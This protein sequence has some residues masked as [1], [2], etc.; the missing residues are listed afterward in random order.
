[1]A[2]ETFRSRISR[3]AGAYQND[4]SC[5][6][7]PEHTSRTH[8]ENRRRVWFFERRRRE[9][10]PGE[11]IWG[12]SVAAYVTGAGAETS[13]GADGRREQTGGLA[14]AA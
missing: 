7:R 5:D 6:N 4:V 8:P 14:H 2:P 3:P 12:S 1:M 11:S 9:S 10:A 13:T